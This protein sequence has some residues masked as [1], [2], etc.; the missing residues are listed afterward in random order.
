MDPVK[1][2]HVNIFFDESGKRK[3]KP[4]LMG[5]LSIPANLYESEKFRSWSMKLRDDQINLHWSSYS[6]FSPLRR[7]IL[8]LI[9]VLASHHYM[10]KFNIINYNYSTLKGNSGTNSYIVEQVI[11]SKFPE[12]LIYGLLRSYGKNIFLDVDICIE[13][14]REYEDLG[15]NYTLKE[16]LNV[17]AL[18]RGEQYSIQNSTLV[19]K[20]EEIGLELTDVLLGM[21]R[22]IILNEAS[23]RSN[24]IAAKNNLVIEC[25]K[26]KSFLS[27][28]GN[29]RLFEWNQMRELTEVLFSDYL[30]LFLANHHDDF[31]KEHKR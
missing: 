4:N 13:H 15:L 17:Q 10:L 7:D 14:A 22:T 11:Y 9:N 12:R 27:F 31:L 6:G 8:Q 18:Y 29:I 5:G 16:S 21:V 28:M 24:G 19:R 26:N 2:E 23:E 1:S 30:Q 3:D 20:K 25:L